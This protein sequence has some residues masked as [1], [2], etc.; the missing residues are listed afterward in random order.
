MLGKVKWFDERR[1][2]GFVQPINEQGLGADHIAHYS[3][4][5]GTGFRTLREGQIVRFESVLSSRGSVARKIEP[6]D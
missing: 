2:F 4:I 5:A 3:E 6:V 1:G